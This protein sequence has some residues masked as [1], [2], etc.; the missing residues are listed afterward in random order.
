MCKKSL[1]FCHRLYFFTVTSRIQVPS[2]VLFCFDI[3]KCWGN[4][5][6]IDL[7]TMFLKKQINDL[8]CNRWISKA[9]GIVVFG[10]YSKVIYVTI[11]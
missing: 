10:I 11:P 4:I 3:R 2:K 8:F 1:L 6:Y 9:H 7:M 5:L